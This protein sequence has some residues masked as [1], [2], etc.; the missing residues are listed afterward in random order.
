MDGQ[1]SALQCTKNYIKEYNPV[2]KSWAT[3]DTVFRGYRDILYSLLEGV[4]PQIIVHNCTEG[5]TL[6]HPRLHPMKL[7]EALK[8]YR[9]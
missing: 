9:V 8:K 4:P 2:W 5:G 3:T 1:Q 7:E 6:N